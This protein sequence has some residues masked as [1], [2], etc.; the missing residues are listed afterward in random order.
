MGVAFGGGR[1]A[2]EGWVTDPN[3]GEKCAKRELSESMKSSKHLVMMLKSEVVQN[4]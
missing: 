2:P 4:E 3:L 1:C